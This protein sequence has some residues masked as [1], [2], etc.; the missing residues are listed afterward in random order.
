M[1]KFLFVILFI[2][3]IAPAI[4]DDCPDGYSVIDDSD[5]CKVECPAGYRVINPGE[6]CTEITGTTPYYSAKHVV[7]YGETSG[8]NVKKCPEPDPSIIYN[9]SRGVSM[10]SSSDHSSINQ[11][12]LYGLR[13]RYTTE[14]GYSP[15]RISHGVLQ[16]PCYYTTGDDGNA[17]YDKRTKDPVTGESRK[18]CVGGGMFFPVMR[19][20]IHIVHILGTLRLICHVNRLDIIIIPQMAI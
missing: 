11:C 18:T 7:V 8:D 13:V 5:L 17:I 3:V 2:W 1:R 9:I 10:P 4:A 12:I 15:S 16:A 14:E 19:D 6:I 20:I